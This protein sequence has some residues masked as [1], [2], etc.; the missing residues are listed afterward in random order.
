MA[1][2]WKW[3]ECPNCGAMAI[4]SLRSNSRPSCSDCRVMYHRV[5]MVVVGWE[6]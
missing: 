6:I 2:I 5:R 3:L 4:K 1:P